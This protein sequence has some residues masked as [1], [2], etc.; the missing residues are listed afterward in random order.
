MMGAMI[1]VEDVSKSYGEKRAVKQ[2]SFCVE[3]ESFFAFLGPNGAGK[4]TTISMLSTLVKKD[5]GKIY[6]DGCDMDTQAEQIRAK[7]GIVFQNCRLDG[8]LSGYENLMVRNGL[9]PSFENARAHIMKIAGMCEIKDFLHQRVDTLS[10]GQRRR[11]DIARAL[12]PNPSLLILDEPTT[13]LDPCSRKELWE[14]LMKLKKKLGMTIFLTTHDMEEA[15]HADRLCIL[16]DGEVRV[17]GSVQ[18]LTR[19]YGHPHLYL[20]GK[21]QDAILQRI[22]T[23]GLNYQRDEGKIIIDVRGYQEA[24]SILR[25]CELLLE[26]FELIHGSLDEAYRRIVGGA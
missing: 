17:Q 19:R 25:S 9:Y 7:L 23:R 5:A 1:R 3:E 26:D 15:R 20:Y 6:I 21:R 18:E 16:M 22:S 8:S 14:M 24:L 4:S 10:G 13:G 12:L 11:L 2:L